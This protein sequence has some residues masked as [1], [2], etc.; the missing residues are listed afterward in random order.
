MGDMK[1]SNLNYVESKKVAEGVNDVLSR[2]LVVKL[3]RLQHKST[4]LIYVLG[5]R[6]QLPLD[7]IILQFGSNTN[8]LHFL[9]SIHSAAL[10]Q[11]AFS[12]HQCAEPLVQVSVKLCQIRRARYTANICGA[13]DG[14][15][16]ILDPVV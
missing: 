3:G 5:T 13:F 12:Y 14:I 4:T 8:C 16:K 6:P 11:L 7:H 10:L 2:A 1:N 9:A 15:G